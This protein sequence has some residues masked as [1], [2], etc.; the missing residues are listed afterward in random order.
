[1]IR[2]KKILGISKNPQKSISYFFLVLDY[3]CMYLPRFS[4]SRTPTAEMELLEYYVFLRTAMGMV[5]V[6]AYLVSER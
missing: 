6:V 4:A 5:F 2:I 3:P 1:M